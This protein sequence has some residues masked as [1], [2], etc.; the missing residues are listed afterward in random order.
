MA[1]PS[2]AVTS[3]LLWAGEGPENAAWVVEE[4]VDGVYVP[5][6]LNIAD[7]FS[8]ES[9]PKSWNPLSGQW[10]CTV[11][12]YPSGNGTVPNINTQI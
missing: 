12:P 7:G 10:K 9:I 4:D 6:S 5:R 8:F 3:A 2:I 11:A 1:I